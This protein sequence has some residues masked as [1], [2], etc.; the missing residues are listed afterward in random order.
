MPPHT[1]FI[2]LSAAIREV[3]V[4]M[5]HAARSDA[6]V[7]ITG[8]SGVGKEIAARLIHQ[9]SRR[10]H[11]PIVTINCAGIPDSL[12]ES[13]LF[14][15]TRGSFTDAYRDRMGLLEL[16]HRGT[17]FLDEVGEMSLRMQ[18]LLLRFLETGELQP[19]GSDR[20]Q[21]R[22]DVR[23]IAATNRDLL[24]RIA[25]QDFREDLYYRLNV[26]H[27]T[28]PPLRVRREDIPVLLRH[29][30]VTY[31]ERH[32]VQPPEL[33]PD[34]LA[35]LVAYDWPGNVRELKNLAE[36]ITVRAP[37]AMLT[38][39]DLPP[40]IVGAARPHG[41]AESTAP[42]AVDVLMDRMLH[43][44]ESFWTAVYPVFMA[45]ELTRSDL[46]LLIAR[47]LQQ[48]GGNYK[49]LAG[50]FNMPAGDYKRFLNFLRRH[51]CDVPY[52]RYR[53]A[54]RSSAES[55]PSEANDDPRRGARR[56]CAAG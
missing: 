19:V 30:F 6:K 50:L 35:L 7:L 14:G 42:S 44:R 39:N 41:I 36:R 4:E 47:G 3:E 15:H 13:E 20:G 11:M 32:G 53:A 31:A 22:V 16:A 45:R 23:V 54:R 12:L 5:E 2:G 55:P 28:I 38:T 9:R 52:Q 46:R 51:G 27:L 25:T 40:E 37:V 26:I 17:I 43:G 21:N 18:A 34:A 33:T 49:M 56:Y 1:E 48:T 8:E 29:F 10:A 24:S